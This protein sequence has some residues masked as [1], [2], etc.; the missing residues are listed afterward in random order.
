MPTALPNPPLLPAAK[1]VP[2][3]ALAIQAF[4]YDERRIVLPALATALEGC[5]CWLLERRPLSVTQTLVRFEIQL[6]C[7]LELY[8][9][10][11]GAGLELTRG[12]HLGLTSLCTLRKHQ[13]R[14]REPYRIL[15]VSLELSFLEELNLEAALLPGA[16]SA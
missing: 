13:R 7:A 14:Q 2:P 11:M 3:P 16:A 12:S 4:T 8:S 9:A 10:L 15:E 1:T 5:G 6:R